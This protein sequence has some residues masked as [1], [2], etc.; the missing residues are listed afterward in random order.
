M[1]SREGTQ[2]ELATSFEPFE[3]KSDYS[4]TRRETLSCA[5]FDWTEYLIRKCVEQVLIRWDLSPSELPR[6]VLVHVE[7]MGNPNRSNW[8]SWDQ[9]VPH[10]APA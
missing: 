10:E 5:V 8:R 4:S 2:Q 7:A 1:G 3:V 9:S 6:H